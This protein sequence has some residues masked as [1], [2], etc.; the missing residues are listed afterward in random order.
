MPISRN[1]SQEIASYVAKMFPRC[2]WTPDE[3]KAFIDRCERLD[4]SREQWEAVVTEHRVNAKYAS[5]NMGDL[6]AELKAASV[7]A[8]SESWERAD[9]PRSRNRRVDIHRKDMGVG[10]STPDDAVMF[11]HAR[12]LMQDGWKTEA[13][14]DYCLDCMMD[15][16]TNKVDAI[17]MVIQ[18]F[19]GVSDVWADG[20]R[21]QF[22]ARKASGAAFW[23][24]Y[25]SKTGRKFTSVDEYLKALTVKFG[26]SER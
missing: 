5:P 6:I 16:R 2:T 25:A 1:S 21:K 23:S 12:R 22:A 20:H 13:A 17:R 24:A 19:P 14:L 8:K 4:V 3:Y 18:A 10:P 11:E 9:R 26:R 7:V 15:Y